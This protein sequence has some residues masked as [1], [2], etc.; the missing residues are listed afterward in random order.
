MGTRD[1]SRR[2]YNRTKARILEHILSG[3]DYIVS[4]EN[5]SQYAMGGLSSCGIVAMNCIRHVLTLEK[6]GCTG[7]DLVV[8]LTQQATVDVRRFHT[9]STLFTVLTRK[10]GNNDSLQLLD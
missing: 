6:D 9:L 4:H 2:E 7:E 8:K 10:P 5:T 3:K 1:L